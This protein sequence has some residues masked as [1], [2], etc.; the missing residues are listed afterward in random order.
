MPP[1]FLGAE[2]SPSD[3]AIRQEEAQHVHAAL[4]A[5]PPHY[6]Q[7]IQLRNFDLLPFAEIATAMHRSEHESRALWVRAMQRLKREL[8]G[9]DH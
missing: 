3:H 6:R 1:E 2:G 7:V 8:D 5:M 4:A 9:L